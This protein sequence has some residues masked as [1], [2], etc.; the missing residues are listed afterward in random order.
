MAGFIQSVGAF[1]KAAVSP[2]MDCLCAPQTAGGVSTGEGA[3]GDASLCTLREGSG[4]VLGAM[5]GASTK[6]KGRRMTCARASP[7]CPAGSAAKSANSSGQWASSHQRPPRADAI[8]A[9]NSS[10]RCQARSERAQPTTTASTAP[11]GRPSSGGSWRACAKTGRYTITGESTAAA[12]SG[13]SLERPLVNCQRPESNSIT[14]L[15]AALIFFIHR[16]RGSVSF[17]SPI[18]PRRVHLANAETDR[19]RFAH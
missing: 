4:P 3:E 1:S 11:T 10:P 9:F 15:S 17:A 16:Y 19:G 5:C 18:L 8:S 6:R 12:S 2:D 13:R 7:A 14:R